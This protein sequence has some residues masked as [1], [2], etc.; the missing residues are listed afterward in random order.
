MEKYQCK[1]S[2]E[3]ETIS[4]MVSEIYDSLSFKFE[5]L[6]Y[7]L[8]PS[9]LKERSPEDEFFKRSQILDGRIHEVIYQIPELAL[10]KERLKEA[11]LLGDGLEIS[12]IF[13]SQIKYIAELIN[14][15]IVDGISD[16]ELK[17][18][19]HIEEVSSSPIQNKIKE[20]YL[21]EDENN[22]RDEVLSEIANQIGRV[23][24][25]KRQ[26]LDSQD[27]Y[28]ISVWTLKNMLRVSYEL[29]KLSVEE[30]FISPAA[31]KLQ[32]IYNK[33]YLELN[34]GDT[35]E[36]GRFTNFSYHHEAIFRNGKFKVWHKLNEN[37]TLQY[38]CEF[39]DFTTAKSLYD[40]L[41]DI[42]DCQFTNLIEQLN[43]QEVDI[44]VVNII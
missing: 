8:T 24:T 43:A 39:K 12:D 33:T 7:H 26:N 21:Q 13:Q 10:L 41:D 30:K 44:K 1:H 9:Q 15:K 2:F 27:F 40:Q 29:G 4:D 22:L 3:R 42:N 32:N 17:N 6:G 5:D 20:I 37:Q 18:I 35:V 38:D 16:G 25:L 36:F 19:E 31:Q 28:D 23:P 14:G 11:E 34:V